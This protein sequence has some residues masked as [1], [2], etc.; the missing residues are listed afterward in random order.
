MRSPSR[1]VAVTAMTALVLLASA[2]KAADPE[3][4]NAAHAAYERAIKAHERGDFAS[5]AREFARADRLIPNDSVLKDAIGEALRADDAPFGAMLVA[6]SARSPD[7]AALQAVAA[8]ANEAFRGRAGRIEIECAS[9]KAELDGSSPDPDADRWLTV[10]PHVVVLTE[11]AHPDYR[12]EHRIDVSP[13]ETTR[14]RFVPPPAR[15]IAR[16]ALQPAPAP[17]AAPHVAPGG[18]SPAWFWLGAG[19]TVALAGATTLSGLDVSSRRRDFS[20]QGCARVGSDTCDAVAS[21]GRGAVTRTNVLLGATALLGAATVATVFLVRW[22]PTLTTS[23]GAGS[24][25]MRLALT[26]RF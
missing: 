10:G 17:P 25:G 19:L 16:P 23:L 12:D 18:I 2:V 7:N 6:R 5:A 1:C 20:D 9:C 8:K 21:D 26:G 24:N 15:A 4:R 3:P 22:K 14:V 11:E 13:L